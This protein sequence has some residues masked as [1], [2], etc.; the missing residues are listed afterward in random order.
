MK[1]CETI[2]VKMD[3]FESDNFLAQPLDSKE[4]TFSTDTRGV[5][6]A[7]TEYSFRLGTLNEKAMYASVDRAY[8]KTFTN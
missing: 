4:K 8:C 6:Y 1:N 7:G 5:F 2:Q 3:F